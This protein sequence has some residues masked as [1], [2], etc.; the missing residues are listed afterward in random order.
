MKG[1]D[2]YHLMVSDEDKK[3]SEMVIEFAKGPG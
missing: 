2:P 1:T 3:I